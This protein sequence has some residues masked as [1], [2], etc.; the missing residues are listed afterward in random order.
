MHNSKMVRQ[1]V[2]DRTT[3]RA[4]R[5]IW[6]VIGEGPR[7]GQIK[8]INFDY[9]VNS[10]L[11][12]VKWVKRGLGRVLKEIRV[13]GDLYE[14]GWRMLEECYENEGM[15][16]EWGT[17]LEY[18]QALRA[19]RVRSPMYGETGEKLRVDESLVPRYVL[20]LRAKAGDVPGGEWQ[21]PEKKKSTRAKKGD[22]AQL[23]S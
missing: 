21:P 11:L 16:E 17:W 6:L 12:D 1:E 4:P 20:N 13:D 2:D 22:D 15:T 9:N 19:G 10:P 5:T 23:A 14:R 3:N 18:Q 8:T 7:A